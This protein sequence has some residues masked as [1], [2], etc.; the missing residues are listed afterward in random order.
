MKAR[1][2]DHWAV[3]IWR[4]GEEVITIET[5]CLSGRVIITPADEEVIRIAA[6]NLLEFIGDP[7]PNAKEPDRG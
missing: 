5:A 3:T 6:R 2:P 1:E 7:A 4:N